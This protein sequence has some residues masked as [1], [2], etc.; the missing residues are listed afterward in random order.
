MPVDT[1]AYFSPDGDVA[2]H[3]VEEI[4]NASAWIDVAIYTFTRKEIADALIAARQRGVSVRVIADTSE[5]DTS[6]AQI[7]RLENAGISV[8]RT[9]GGGGGIMH[10]KYAIFDEC[11]LFTGSYN[12]STAAEQDNDENAVFLRD[13]AVIAAYQNDFNVIWVRKD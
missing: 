9:D 12:W 10:N 4:Q 8:K 5:A 7:A 13:A 3:I 6:G 2:A 11:L 1:M